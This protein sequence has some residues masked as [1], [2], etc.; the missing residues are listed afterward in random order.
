M[1]KPRF[2]PSLPGPSLPVIVLSFPAAWQ[3]P[4]AGM[5][6]SGLL[7]PHHPR[8]VSGEAEAQECPVHHHVARQQPEPETQEPGH[9]GAARESRPGRQLRQPSQWKAQPKAGRQTLDPGGRGAEALLLLQPLSSAG[10]LLPV[11]RWQLSP[12][13]A[14]EPQ[15][16]LSLHSTGSIQGVTTQL[17]L[18]YAGLELCPLSSETQCPSLEVTWEFPALRNGGGRGGSLCKVPCL[19]QLS[20]GLG[21][22]GSTSSRQCWGCV[23]W[24][25]AHSPRGTLW[26]SA[27]PSR[28]G[29]PE[30]PWEACATVFAPCK[31][32]ESPRGVLG[33]Q[34]ETPVPPGH[35]WQPFSKPCSSTGEK[36][37][38]LQHCPP[39]PPPQSRTPRVTGPARGYACSWGQPG[40]GPSPTS[41]WA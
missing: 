5:A 31:G 13:A 32:P 15:S 33:Q 41:H 9:C 34:I 11:A 36:L 14:V 7:H 25:P 37:P 2:L 24:S 8:G 3:N 22:R 39:L 23:G 40:Q 10:A 28:K 16:G 35:C 27:F 38:W 12:S 6:E 26:V 29:G 4:G 1:R 17:L 20:S 21:W 18:A 30:Q 19:L